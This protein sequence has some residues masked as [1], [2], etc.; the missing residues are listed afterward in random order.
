[1]INQKTEQEKE[2]IR[3]YHRDYRR[4]NKKEL[5]EKEKEIKRQYYRDYYQR[6]RKE[7]KKRQ[8]NRE[9][10]QR[11]K[12]ANPNPKKRGRK[13]KEKAT[14]LKIKKSASPFILYFD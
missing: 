12:V 5:T 3:Q 13:P 4:R 7:E 1:M 14:P 10:Y 9:Y 2:K 11:T 6:K 8:Y